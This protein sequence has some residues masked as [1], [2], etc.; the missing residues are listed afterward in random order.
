MHNGAILVCSIVAVA[1]L[2]AQFGCQRSSVSWVLKEPIGGSGPVVPGRQALTT[3]MTAQGQGVQVFAECG[4]DLCH[5]QPGVFRLYEPY[6]VLAESYLELEIVRLP[7]P[8]ETW[9]IQEAGVSGRWTVFGPGLF[10]QLVNLRAS[11]GTVS[12]NGT[13]MTMSLEYEGPVDQYVSDEKRSSW[14]RLSGGQFGNLQDRTNLSFHL[15]TRYSTEEAQRLKQWR[16]E[17]LERLGFMQLPGM[18]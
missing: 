12:W 16:E 13:T 1:I 8:G 2:S 10:V 5:R 14:R 15:E 4:H 6:P 11:R 17:A 9:S 3:A 7:P 18:R